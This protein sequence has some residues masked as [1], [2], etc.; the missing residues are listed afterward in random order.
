VKNFET[1]IWEKVEDIGILTLN[2][3]DRFNAVNDTLIQEF[4]LSLMA[5]TK[6]IASGP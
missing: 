6:T 3:P 4:V 1:I 5:L 2:R